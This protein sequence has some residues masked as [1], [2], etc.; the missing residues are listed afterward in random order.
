MRKVI[1]FIFIS[2][3]VL[4]LIPAIDIAPSFIP[5]SWNLGDIEVADDIDIKFTDMEGAVLKDDEGNVDTLAFGTSG[6]YGV[7]QFKISYEITSLNIGDVY[8][9]GNGDLVNSTDPDD[10]LSWTLKQEGGGS[11][12]D[13][14]TSEESGK[15]VLIM[16]HYPSTNGITSKGELSY[17][18]QTENLLTRIPDFEPSV[19]YETVITVKW[20]AKS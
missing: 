16:T 5:V 10:K 13:V 1:S 9:S 20:E 11:W 2:L 15:W 18:I 12:K 4:Y 8:I 7:G 14:L 6:M 3:S 17:Q 19:S